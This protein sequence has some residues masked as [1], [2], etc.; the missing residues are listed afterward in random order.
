MG[1]VAKAL[2]FLVFLEIKNDSSEKMQV[3]QTAQL[4]PDGDT[5]ANFIG[6]EFVPPVAGNFLES[7]NPATG[8]PF[9]RVPDS[10]A[11]DVQAAVEAAKKAFPTWSQLPPEQRAQFLNRIADLIGMKSR[12]ETLTKCH[13]SR[14]KL[15]NL[16]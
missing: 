11:V 12:E 16:C 14:T 5:L 10:D 9:L 3:P 15:G 2:S 4:L 1:E 7:F 13:H 6:G 8:R